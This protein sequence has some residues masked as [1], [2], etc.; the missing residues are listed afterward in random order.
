M[1]A[2]FYPILAAAGSGILLSL[3]F[4]NIGFDF[5]IWVALVPLLWAIRDK[6]PGKAFVLGFIA[7]LVHS[8]SLLYW[9]YHV[10]QFYGGIP[11]LLALA[12]LLLFTVYLGLYCAAFCGIIRYTTDSYGVMFLVV[13]P[14]TWVALELVRSTF[15]TG[16]PW[17]LLGQAHYRHLHLIQIA[18]LVGVYGI[19]FL[20]VIINVAFYTLV[21]ETGSWKK[22][23]ASVPVIVAASLL[24]AVLL[25]GQYRLNNFGPLN[26]SNS[27]RVALVQGNIDQSSKWDP[28]FRLSTI[29]TYITLSKLAAEGGAQLVIWPETAMPFYYERDIELTDKVK[30]F[31]ERSNSY[32]IIGSPA[33]V[34]EDNDYA[35]R[36]RAFLISPNGITNGYYD[37]VHLVPYGEY[38]PLKRFFPFIKK[39]VVAAGNFTAGEI[40]DTLPYPDGALGPLICYESV[41][42]YLSRRQVSNGAKLLVNITNDAWFGHTGAPLQHL[43]ILVFRCIE[44]RRWAVRAANTGISSIIRPTGKIEKQSPIFQPFL[45]Q[46]KVQMIDENTFYMRYGDV[47]AYVCGL[48]A[49]FLIARTFF[50]KRFSSKSLQ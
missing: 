9:V 47:F 37:K 42:P 50:T 4:P 1:A 3:S 19:S 28:E 7:G 24:A 26:E 46:G 22:R 36:N 5:L 17:G 41:F 32:Y 25:Y 34:R 6:S 16:F 30:K 10:M 38:V 8:L 48:A 23:L 33:V 40:G 44:N 49:V 21:L 31:I 20:V 29:E 45:I 39:L 11:G 43:S 12:I 15:L 2:N 27:L 18:D 35:H 14:V 13:A